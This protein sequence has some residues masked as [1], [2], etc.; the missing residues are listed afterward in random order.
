[1]F[2]EGVVYASSLMG[3]TGIR[4]SVGKAMG[5]L[6]RRIRAITELP[7]CVGIGIFN[8]AQEAVRACA[9]R[10]GLCSDGNEC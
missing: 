4:E 1:V 10:C 3:V 7:V 9:D 6:M 5:S 2:V 8:A